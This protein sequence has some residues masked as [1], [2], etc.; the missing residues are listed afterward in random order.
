M[1][2]STARPKRGKNRV[3]YCT[4]VGCPK[5]VV[6]SGFCDIHYE[7]GRRAALR[8]D[9]LP[10]TPVQVRVPF[11]WIGDEESLAKMTEQKDRERANGE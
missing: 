5:R 10:R 8:N 4:A 2:R 1:A 3:R 7:L 6:A 11:E 9:T